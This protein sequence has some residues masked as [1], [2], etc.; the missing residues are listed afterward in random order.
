MVAL[1]DLLHDLVRN[2][3]LQMVSLS[4]WSLLL[5][6]SGFFSKG[7]ILREKPIKHPRLCSYFV[8]NLT[9]SRAP[10]FLGEIWRQMKRGLGNLVTT[11][12]RQTQFS[13]PMFMSHGASFPRA[14]HEIR[15]LW[16]CSPFLSTS[17]RS[18]GK[19]RC[20]KCVAATS[21]PA[22]PPGQSWSK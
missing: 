5:E 3:K 2:C 10:Q 21:K 4:L 7:F 18:G 1:Q 8:V 9:G 11:F 15:G 14:G 20:L 12:Q 6:V 13:S 16:R 17:S 19:V 22:C